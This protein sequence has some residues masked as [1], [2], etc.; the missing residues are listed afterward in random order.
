MSLSLPSPPSLPPLPHTFLFSVLIPIAV[1]SRYILF[2]TMSTIRR[3]SLDTIPKRDVIM[4]EKQQSVDLVDYHLST[5]RIIWTDSSSNSIMASDI[6][7]DD[8]RVLKAGLRSIGG[9]AVDWITGNVYYTDTTLNRIGVVSSK[10]DHLLSVKT[11]VTHP[12]SIAVD[13]R[14]GSVFISEWVISRLQI[15][16]RSLQNWV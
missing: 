11:I 8:P 5:S 12:T 14:K 6:N 9:I 7:G 2:S 13:P 3:L 15:F 1:P 16:S 10:Y 4:V